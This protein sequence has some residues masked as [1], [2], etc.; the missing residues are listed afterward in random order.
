MLALSLRYRKNLIMFSKACEYG[1]RAVLFIA[2]RSSQNERS[3]LKEIAKEIKAPEAFVAK[4]LQKLVRKDIIHSSTGPKGGFFVDV[5]E[6]KNIKMIEIVQA[7]DGN[8]IFEGCALGLP[9]CDE[10]HP[11][12]VHHKF[13]SIRESLKDMMM[14]MDVSQM[15]DNI[16]N[17]IAFLKY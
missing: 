6:I 12:P 14:N 4:V 7:I 17:E 5:E 3:R 1:I 9:K 13:K 10:K 15:A 11:C 2:L 8:Q 16:D